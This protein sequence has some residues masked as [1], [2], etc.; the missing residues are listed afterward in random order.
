MTWL[1]LEGARALVL[2]AGGLGAAC[3]RGMAESGARPLVVDVD[4]EKLS[5]LQKETA[6]VEVLCGDLSSAAGSE[7]AASKGGLPGRREEMTT[8]VPAGR[9][10]VPQDVVGAVLFLLPAHAAFLTGQVLHID[11]GRTLV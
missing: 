9:L 3:A 6:G 7:Q 1:G 2:G 11:G 10:G 8:L 4:A 5:L